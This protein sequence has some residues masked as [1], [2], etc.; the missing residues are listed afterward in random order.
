MVILHTP[1]PLRGQDLTTVGDFEVAAGMTVPFVLTHGSSHL[2][3][4]DAI[5]PQS[6]LEH[7][8]AFWRDWAARGQ[9][10]RRMVR[11]RHALA[12]HA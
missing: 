10:R 6:S 5:D 2:P 12:D 1:V 8:E 9:S 7:T 11:R 3:P 4:P